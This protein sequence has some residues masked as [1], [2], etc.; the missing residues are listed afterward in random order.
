MA[1]EDSSVNKEHGT[2][3]CQPESDLQHSDRIPGG[4]ICT[5]AQELTSQ[6]S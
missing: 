3:E 1:R 4:V 5:R 6:S 2:Q